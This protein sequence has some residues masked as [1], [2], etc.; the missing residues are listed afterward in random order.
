MSE[1][2]IT[3]SWFECGWGE[4]V[5]RFGGLLWDQRP[6]EGYL[7]KVEYARKRREIAARREDAQLIAAG[8]EPLWRLK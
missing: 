3:A 5:H 2:Q 1:P 8:E 7:R 6:P 4:Y